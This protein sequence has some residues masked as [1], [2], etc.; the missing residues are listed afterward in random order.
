M[1]VEVGVFVVPDAGE[2]SRTVDQVLAAEEAGLDLVAIQD[3]PYQRSFLDTFMLLANLAGRTSRIRLA[4]DVANLPLRQP[5]MLAKAAASIDLLS[6][7]RF[8]LGLG[9]GSR[10]DRIAAMGGPRLSRGEAVGALEEAIEVIRLWWSG[11]PEVSFAGRHYR[12]EA[13]T[14]GPKPAHPIPIWIGAYR[15]RMLR[16]TGRLGDGW[17]PSLG[18]LPEE[19]MAERHR[20]IDEAARAA[21][22]DPSEVRRVLNV[23]VGEDWDGSVERLAALVTE[24]GFETLIVSVGQH[25]P[26]GFVRRVGEEL[27][28]RLREAVA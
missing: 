9:A 22:R 18:Y 13:A 15:P 4:P 23:G 8:V 11:E 25:D 3:H 21:G 26:V 27:A 7:G 6:G 16:L 24:R 5:A 14:P 2:P 28:P 1:S 10:F 12:L 17:L 19:E 20:A